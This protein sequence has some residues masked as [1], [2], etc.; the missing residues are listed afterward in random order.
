MDFNKCRAVAFDKWYN[1]IFGVPKTKADLRNKAL[2]EKA[3][4]AAV[5]AV[6][7]K[8]LKES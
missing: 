4:H 1:S 8:F 2:A 5:N 6:E 3:W 7:Y